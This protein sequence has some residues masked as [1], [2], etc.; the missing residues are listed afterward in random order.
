MAEEARRGDMDVDAAVYAAA[1]RDPTWPILLG[2]GTLEAPVGVLGRDPGRFE[3]IEA[4]PF[5]GKGGQLI[6]DGFHRARHGTSCPDLAASVEVGRS[7]FWCNT[8][9][10][11]PTGNKAWS[12]KVKRRFVDPIAT[13]I[14][15]RWSGH[16]LITCGNVAFDW[17]RLADKELK[18][19]L[20]E[21]WQRP[22][23]Y[24]ASLAIRLR[25]KEIRLHPLPHPSPLN[26]TWYP[27]FP[28]LLDAR[29]QSLGWS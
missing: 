9:P 28:G 8:V 7:V 24:E 25:G 14:C 12:V 19:P 20:A 23:R 3:V 10:F 18:G 5:I 4:E 22:D 21:F 15:E 29:L 26:A 16:D 17:F 11:K 6:R 2:S 13:L 27:K 1:E